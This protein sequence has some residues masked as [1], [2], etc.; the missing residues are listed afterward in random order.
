MDSGTSY[1][2]YSRQKWFTYFNPLSSPISVVLGDNHSILATGVGR[3]IVRMCANGEWK[4]QMLQNVLYVPGLHGNLLSID[5]ATEVTFKL[6]LCHVYNYNGELICKEQKRGTAYIIDIEVPR[7]ETAHITNVK[8]FPSEGDEMPMQVLA[9]HPNVSKASLE[10]W[11][12]RLRHLSHNMVDQ[13]LCKGMVTRMEFTDKPLSTGPCKP[14]LKGKQT[15]TDISKV[16]NERS[17]IVLGC[18][19]SDLCE[20]PTHSHHGYNYFATFIDD[21]LRNV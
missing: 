19:F 11:H 9:T 2:M 3:V 13:M 20:Q 8:V 7:P 21:K 18:I 10:M 4:H 6:L 17:E 5:C 1:T 16:A 15:C 14:C 12:R